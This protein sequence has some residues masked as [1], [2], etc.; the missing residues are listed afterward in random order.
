M[1]VV[2]RFQRVR[3][4]LVSAV[5]I[6]WVLAAPG[7]A[8]AELEA[9]PPQVSPASAGGQ[10]KG[11]DSTPH[12]QTN[13]KEAARAQV[14][15][16]AAD[17]PT[18]VAQPTDTQASGEALARND[19]GIADPEL[20]QGDQAFAAEDW[21]LAGRAYEAARRKAPADPAAYV[22]LARVRLAQ[23]QLPLSFAAA[24]G[25]R[26]AQAALALVDH[27]LALD[28]SYGLAQ[29]ER[30]RILLILG[31]ARLAI[32]SFAKAQQLLPRSAEAYGG[33]GIARLA[34]GAVKEA[35]LGFKE[36]ARL[37]PG[38]AARLGNL[39]TAHL[40]LGEVPEALQVYR[41][42]AQLA[43]EDARAQGD[44]GT[45]LLALN[46]PA[47]ALIFLEKAHHLAPERATF[48]SN[49]GYAKELQGQLALA[50]VSYQQALALDPKLASAWINLGVALSHQ[51]KFA[52]AEAALKRALALDPTDP[53]AKVN[54]EELRELVRTQAQKP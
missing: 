43:P 36:A 31:E 54:L 7:C 4:S 41:E 38:N 8:P 13:G 33:M 26:V 44:V 51:Q 47:E 3:S 14:P 49:I 46:Q 12:P 11:R 42:A 5:G 24:P 32:E 16:N 30:G 21:R 6:A 17:P 1:K 27:A 45:A 23:K 25:D 18:K 22:G 2:D 37:D 20:S 15:K 35:L 28:S 50:I 10:A 39:G 29:L 19:N 53:R 52:E 34:T 9:S 48:L 40:M